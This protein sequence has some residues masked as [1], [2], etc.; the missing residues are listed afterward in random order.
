LGAL[1][2]V[3]TINSIAGYPTLRKSYDNPYSENLFS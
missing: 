1:I 3:T 2:L